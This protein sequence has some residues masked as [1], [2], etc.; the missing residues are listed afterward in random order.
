MLRMPAIVLSTTPYLA[1]RPAPPD[2]TSVRPRSGIAKISKKF[3]T[4]GPDPQRMKLD[5][6][7]GRCRH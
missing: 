2:L 1:V 6:L 4:G 7:S 3:F 5:R